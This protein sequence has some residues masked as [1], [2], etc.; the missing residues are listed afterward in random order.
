M[1]IDKVIGERVRAYRL[2]KGLTQK[3]LS[4][5]LGITSEQLKAHEAGI[6]RIVPSQLW[7]IA[8]ALDISVVRLFQ[9]S[10]FVGPEQ[11]EVENLLNQFDDLPAAD[12]SRVVLQM[13][14]LSCPEWKT[15]PPPA[16]RRPQ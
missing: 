2:A 7:K 13:R 9:K 15:I 16:T 14:A 6:Q 3:D 4:Q 1:Q 10:V 11:P 12:K 8:D 5:T